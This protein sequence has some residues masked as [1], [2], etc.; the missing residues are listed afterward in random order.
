M[1][2]SKLRFQFIHLLP[3]ATTCQISYL[4][5]S[6]KKIPSQ[7]YTVPKNQGNIG[8][9]AQTAQSEGTVSLQRN[10]GAGK[11]HMWWILSH[12]IT[13][14]ANI[15]GKFTRDIPSLSQMMWPKIATFK[16]SIWYHDHCKHICDLSWVGGFRA[17]AVRGAAAP[18]SVWRP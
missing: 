10:T 15:Q 7:N 6:Q 18:S 12:P 17:P 16:P 3:I 8:Q 4:K 11:P 1:H 5:D 14:S 9:H 13:F 2:L